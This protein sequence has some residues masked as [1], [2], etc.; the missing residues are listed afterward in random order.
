MHLLVIHQDTVA[1]Q[2]LRFG[3]NDTLSAHVAALVQ[4]NWLFLM[5]DVDY[6]YTSNPKTDPKAKPIYEVSNF[7]IKP[8]D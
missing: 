6:L 4:A 2:E 7:N 5:T 3:D 1:V 8:Q